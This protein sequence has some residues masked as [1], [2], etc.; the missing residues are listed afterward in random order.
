MIHSISVPLSIKM[1]ANC[2][3][4]NT[5][6]ML[7]TRYMKAVPMT[8][9]RFRFIRR[10]LRSSWAKLIRLDFFLGSKDN[11]RPEDLSGGSV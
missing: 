1:M 9:K 8:S 10:I 2:E 6:E 4:L 3:K 11:L 7:N 5:P